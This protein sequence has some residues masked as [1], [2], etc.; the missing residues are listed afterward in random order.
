MAEMIENL[1]ALRS[2]LLAERANSERLMSA[3]LRYGRCDS[4]C[5]TRRAEEDMD[6]VCDCGY[7][8]SLRDD[9]P[10]PF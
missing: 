6:S 2:G 4:A 1:H 7:Y 10:D 8:A 3:L 9:T 5:A